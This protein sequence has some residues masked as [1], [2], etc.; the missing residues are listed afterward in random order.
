MSEVYIKDG[1]LWR[2]CDCCWK[3]FPAAD[4][5]P[6]RVPT[7]LIPADPNAEVVQ[8]RKVSFV[9]PQ[10]WESETDEEGKK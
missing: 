10:C 8:T 4:C 1:V 5:K 3:H 7:L 9:C 2:Q 6:Y